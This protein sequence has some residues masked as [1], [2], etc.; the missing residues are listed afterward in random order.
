[1]DNSENDGVRAAK[2]A[3]FALALFAIGAAFLFWLNPDNLYLWIKALHIIAVITWMAGMFYLPRLFVYH[4]DTKAGSEQAQT[5]KIME[6]RLLRV[7]INPAMIFTWIFGLWL[8][9]SG[10]AFKGA[11][12]HGKIF[13]VLLLSGFHGYLSKQVRVF[14]NDQNFKSAKYWRMMNEVPTLLMFIIVI[15]V[16]VKPF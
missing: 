2:R 5:F 3:F 13:F 11:W 14:A 15:L 6:R 9:W 8:A 7:I 12:L 4:A 1:M 16:V 10:F